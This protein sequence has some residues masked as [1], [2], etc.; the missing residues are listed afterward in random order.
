MSQLTISL[1]GPFQVTLNGQ[2]VVRFEADAARALL[3][4][5]AMAPTTAFRRDALAAL[6]WPRQP[7]SNARH[8][9]RQTLLR[10]RR[11]I[12]DGE[13]SPPFLKITRTTIQ[14]EPDS[15]YELD[16]VVFGDLLSAA[17]QHPHNSIQE[18]GLCMDRL[19]LAVELLRGDFMAGFS[20]N[21]TP[22]EEWMVIQQEALHRRAI[23]LLYLLADCCE[24]LGRYEKAQYYARRQIELE[25]WHEPAYRQLM[26]TL[27]LSGQRYA[28]VL[29]CKVCNRILTQEFGLEPE[30]ETTALCEVIRLGRL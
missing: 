9:L 29:Q 25:P 4:Y 2:P 11:A 27:A 5:L 17:K 20:L 10:L 30:E 14:F 3:A 12:G 13:A 6:L 15:D 1:L 26:R 23:D 7:E 22:F 16:M 28:A 24:K 8:N 19:Q 18:C 21:S